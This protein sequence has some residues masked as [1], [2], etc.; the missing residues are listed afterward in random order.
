MPCMGKILSF[1]AYS[2]HPQ[3]HVCTASETG[4]GSMGCSPGKPTLNEGGQSQHEVSILS[5]PSSFLLQHLL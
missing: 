1:R 4:Q 2:L 3:E 5:V